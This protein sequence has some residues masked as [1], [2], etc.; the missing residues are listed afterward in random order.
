MPISQKTKIFH[1]F[2]SLSK[3]MKWKMVDNFIP[4]H[5][6][7]PSHSAKL[8]KLFAAPIVFET[9]YF[10]A[11]PY[12]SYARNNNALCAISLNRWRGKEGLVIIRYAPRLL[13]M[14][15]EGIKMHYLQ[16][17]IFETNFRFLS[18]D[19]YYSKQKFF[20]LF[21]AQIASGLRLPPITR[22]F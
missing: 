1:Q 19:C 4:Y 5:L 8:L 20:F 3:S 2:S 21:L 18:G 17:I 16:R 9:H 22:Q 13:N 7:A 14:P 6:Y 15:R 10:Y 11:Y 12:A